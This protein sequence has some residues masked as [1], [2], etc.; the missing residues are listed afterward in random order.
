MPERILREQS[1]VE[2]FKELVESA[3]EH[4]HIA[5]GELTAYYVV[6][7]L[8]TF[9]RIDRGGRASRFV[10]EPLALRLGR[11]LESGGSAQ[12]AELRELGDLS[13]FTSGFFSDSFRRKPID[14]DYY[15]ALGG[16]AYS[17]LSRH[18]DG[19]F[20]EVFAELAEKF[21]AFVDV[22]AEVSERTALTSNTD[23]LRLYE[24]WLR[25]GSRRSGE[26]LVE[27]GIV[28]NVSIG[29]RFLQ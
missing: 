10:D 19:S 6:N 21:A 8:S 13:L 11:A 2:Y 4:Q 20:A 27:R 1:P 18:E 22:L 7:L 28:P 9:V 3:L 24:R 12:R 26:Q 25:T 16:Y 23:V 17:S 29:Q 15:I 5:A 14:I